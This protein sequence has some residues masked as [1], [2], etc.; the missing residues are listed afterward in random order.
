M[1]QPGEN[2]HLGD[3]FFPTTLIIQALIDQGFDTASRALAELI[4][5]SI[6]ATATAVHV[7]CFSEMVQNNE[8][9]G[10]RITKIAVLDNG[11]GMDETDLRKALQFGNGTRLG[12]NKGLG[13]FG[14]GL[15]SA[16]ISQCD[17]TE[18]FSW[19]NGVDSA[20]KTTLSLPAVKAGTVNV[21]WPSK[22]K[23]DS[24]VEKFA[25]DNLQ[26]TGSLIVW[27]DLARLVPVRF[28]ALYLQLEH[29]AGRM[30]RKHIHSGTVSIFVHDVYNGEERDVKSVVPNDPL[31]LM[32]PSNTPWPY[33]DKC[34][35][36][37]PSLPKMKKDCR[38][39][40]YRLQLN[41]TALNLE[42]ILSLYSL[43][44]VRLILCAVEQARKLSNKKRSRDWRRSLTIFRC[45][46]F[47]IFVVMKKAR[48]VH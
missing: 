38:K 37:M 47:T 41:V 12:A 14:M 13:K 19:K 17:I 36:R 1:S 5:N 35:T 40:G 4:D 46:T 20:L 23:I 2:S 29:L 18:V 26:R 33:S 39:V 27:R 9:R 21:P 28:N 16:S 7:Y 48:P 45:P 31:Y 22:S 30:Y 43:Q 8:R 34:V 25:K 3:P 32:H 42:R 10:E 11:I 6:Q 44:R 15:P 24:D